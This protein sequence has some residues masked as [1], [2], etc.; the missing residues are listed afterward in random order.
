[1]KKEFVPYDIALALKEIG[2]DED[3]FGCYTKDNELSLDY[4]NN[5]DE[6]HYFQ[7][8]SAP[9]YQQAFDFFRENSKIAIDIYNCNGLGGSEGYGYSISIEDD[10]TV[11]G[12]YGNLETGHNAEPHLPYEEVRLMC[13]KKLI[14]ISQLKECPACKGSGKYYSYTWRKCKLC[15][16]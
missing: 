10:S 13:L 14:D 9:L 1:M 7:K 11:L 8:C 4:S 6:G 12:K 5:T 15:E 16:I 3:C 2:F